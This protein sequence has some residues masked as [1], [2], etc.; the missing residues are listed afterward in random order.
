MIP[1]SRFRGLRFFTGP[2]G[3]PGFCKGIRI[4]SPMSLINTSVVQCR[5]KTSDN[6]NLR[7]V[8]HIFFYSE[9]GE[10][11]VG[12]LYPILGFGK[13]RFIKIAAIA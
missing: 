8:I 7:T 6:L 12:Q 9:E 5:L 10:S 2:S 13:K 1:L 11:G 4:L 3:L